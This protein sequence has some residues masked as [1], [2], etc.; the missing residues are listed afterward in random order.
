MI[1]T[2]KVTKYY[3]AH[4]AIRDL[5]FSI[6]EGEVVGLLGLNGAGKTTTLRMLSGVLLPTSGRI[7]IDGFDL[8][9]SPE[10]VRARIGFLPERPPL[11]SEM[12]VDD[13]LAFV[14]RIKGVRKGAK[15]LVERAL[16]ATDLQEVRHRPIGVLSQGFQRRVGIAQAIVHQPKLILLDEPTSGLDP[17]Q[18]VHMRALIKNL[19]EKHTV[20]VSS[21]ILSEIGQICDR[22]FVLRQGELVAE[23]T[24]DDLS[25]TIR[26]A[27]AVRVEVR[28]GEAEVASLMNDLDFVQ[29]VE[30]ECQDGE[31]STFLVELKTDSREALARTLVGANYGLLRLERARLELEDVFL[32]LT[33]D[34][35]REEA[36]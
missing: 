12:T 35:V 23:G 25:R 19:R 1:E 13:Y 2:S 21:H 28:G 29:N 14:V 16:D 26:T 7:T 36:A 18:I 6:G 4:A 22:I 3:G 17:V 30:L 31:C 15:A 33:G 8:S 20:L 5:S 34:E 32:T 10:A 27:Y 9:R 11:Y 24:E